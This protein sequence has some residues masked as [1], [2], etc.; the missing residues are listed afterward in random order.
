[1][2][3]DVG[4]VRPLSTASSAVGDDGRVTVTMPIETLPEAVPLPANDPSA[5]TLADHI[6]ALVTQARAE[7][8]RFDRFRRVWLAT[9]I[10]VLSIVTAHVLSTHNTARPAKIA[11]AC[12]AVAMLTWRLTVGRMID[13]TN[14]PR[15]TI[16]YM[17]GLLA[18]FAV[19]VSSNPN[20]MYVLFALNPEAVAAFVRFRPA[21]IASCAF[22]TVALVAQVLWL[23]YLDSGGLPQGAI[24]VLII[25]VGLALVFFF[26]FVATQSRQRSELLRALQ[27]SQDE[28]RRLHVE[29][30]AHAERERLSR[31]IHDTVAQGLASIVMLLEG[32]ESVVEDHPEVP[33]S[34]GRYLQRAQRSA[35]DSLDETRS[36]IAGLRPSALAAASLPEA[37]ER[38]LSRAGD[39]G[40]FTTE[41]RCRGAARPLPASLDV[42]LLRIAQEAL[43]NVIRHADAHRVTL[44]LCFDDD[45]M[46]VVNDDGVGFDQSSM[47]SGFGFRGMHERA[48]Q[49]GGQ[50]CVTS[51]PGH[52]TTVHVVVP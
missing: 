38:T 8:D 14:R 22:A 24:S 20:G 17:A 50:V 44:E 45:I 49:L 34:I 4:S 19:L 9:F 35:R 28:L 6:A 31:E 32:A 11:M 7:G 48:A 25:V 33:L 46:L 40:G 52:G 16:V 12:G 18:C 29:A 51:R 42:V 26:A 47:T 1:V 37:L 39:T 10:I 5:S 23:G 43:A 3:I 30:G 2:S 41:M 36:L 15:L 27:S 13:D 21:M